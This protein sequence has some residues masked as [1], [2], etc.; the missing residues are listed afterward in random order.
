MVTFLIILILEHTNLSSLKSGDHVNV[1]VDILAKYMSVYVAIATALERLKK[2]SHDYSR[3][4]MKIARMKA[5]S[6]W[7][8]S[9]HGR[10]HQFHH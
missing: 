7:L 6:Y 4:T 5:T 3:G 2:R 10:K 8:P 1:E 9:T